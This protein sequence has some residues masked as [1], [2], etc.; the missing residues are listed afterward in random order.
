MIPISLK[1]VHMLLMLDEF[2]S[3]SVQA[4]LLAAAAGRRRHR[5]PRGRA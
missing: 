4:A 3:I 1:A 5:D 2:T